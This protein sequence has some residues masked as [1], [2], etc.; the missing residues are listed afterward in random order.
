MNSSRRGRIILSHCCQLEGQ[1]QRWRKDVRIPYHDMPGLSNH[2]VSVLN[3]ARPP[4]GKPSAVFRCDPLH[5]SV[6]SVPLHPLVPIGPLPIARHGTLVALAT[7]TH[8][9]AATVHLRGHLVPV[10]FPLH[11]STRSATLSDHR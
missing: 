9:L 11:M 3:S 8:D 7:R 10:D 1:P 4:R 2:F 5:L 6:S